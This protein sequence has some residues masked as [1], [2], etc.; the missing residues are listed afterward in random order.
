[1]NSWKKEKKVSSFLGLKKNGN[2]SQSLSSIRPIKATKKIK[3]SLQYLLLL[4]KY[5]NQIDY[6]NIKL[7]RAFLTKYGKIRSR[8]KTKVSVQQQKKIAQAIRK[9]RAYKLIPFTCSVEK[10]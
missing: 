4:K 10:K 1:M 3:K 6:K 5:E 2:W 7:L 8:R 9:S